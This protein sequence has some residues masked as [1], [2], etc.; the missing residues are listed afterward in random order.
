MSKVLLS[1]ITINLN[2]LDGLKRT[3]YSITN[4]LSYDVE[5]IVVDGYSIDGS[6]EF[7]LSNSS[8]INHLVVEKDEGIYFAMN[9]GASLS[10]GDFLFFLNSGDELCE[11]AINNIIENINFIKSDIFYGK[12]F[13]TVN[14]NGINKLELINPDL[15]NLKNSMSIFH[16]STLINRHIFFEIG[17]YNTNYKLA[18]DYYFFLKAFVSNYK[19]S[20]LDFPISIFEGGGFSSNNAFLSLTESIKLKFEILPFYISVPSILRMV[21]KFYISTILVKTGRFFLSKSLY[22]KISSNFRF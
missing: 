10:N 9:K 18:A 16:P 21:C 14:N 2:N 8:L 11:N 1:I 17:S 13:L 12:I 7:L 15:S 6:V 22:S 5:F 19:F 4:Q 20:F 3:F